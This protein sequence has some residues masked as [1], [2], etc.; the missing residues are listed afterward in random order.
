MLNICLVHFRR[1]GPIGFHK[2]G[3][4]DYGDFWQVLLEIAVRTAQKIGRS[5]LLMNTLFVDTAFGPT[6]FL[7]LTM[8]KGAQTMKCT[9]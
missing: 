1:Q 8:L 2:W 9:L 6:R 5:G 4:H 7:L 3:I